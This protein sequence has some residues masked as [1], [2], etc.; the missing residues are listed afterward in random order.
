MKPEG[1]IREEYL[2]SEFREAIIK[3]STKI[4]AFYVFDI[5][6]EHW[7]DPKLLEDREKY[8]V[9]GLLFND[10]RNSVLADVMIKCIEK[11]IDSN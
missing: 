7:I 5:A 11:N 3:D 9:N 2:L 8:T 6:K 1:L 10:S 4:M